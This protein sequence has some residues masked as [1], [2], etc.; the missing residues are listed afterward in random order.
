MRA[1]RAISEIP[2]H[3]HD[4]VELLNLDRDRDTPDVD[5]DRYGYG[6]AATLILD[7]SAG[8]EASEPLLVRNALVLALHSADQGEVLA[9]D[10]EL[11][12]FVPEVAEDYSVTVLLS[13]FLDKW[14]PGLMGDEDAIVLALCNAHRATISPPAIARGTPVYY[15]LGDVESWLE[16]EDGRPW[17][18]LVAD[19]WRVADDTHG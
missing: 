16:I 6:R 13:A 17:I 7:S 5:Y 12:F 15:A 14:L 2:F 18:R 4:V 10:I 8:S 3:E 11:E 9:R 1:I 19:Q